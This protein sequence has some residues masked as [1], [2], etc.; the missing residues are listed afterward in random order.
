MPGDE[1]VFQ[2]YS[3]LL[4]KDK[5]THVK[6]KDRKVDIIIPTSISK[7]ELVTK[8]TLSSVTSKEVDNY[9]AS[10][11]EYDEE[12]IQLYENGEYDTPVFIEGDKYG[13]QYDIDYDELV[14]EDEE[15][16]M[17][18]IEESANKEETLVDWEKY[19]QVSEGQQCAAPLRFFSKSSHRPIIAISS[20]PGSGKHFK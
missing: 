18:N 12:T 14:E 6:I 5:K 3:A 13:D 1:N 20:F 4:V 15:Y 17:N 2:D 16:E 11:D 7:G 8:P 10:A 9:D 19:A